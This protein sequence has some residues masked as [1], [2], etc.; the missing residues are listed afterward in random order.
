MEETTEELLDIQ[1]PPT[2][3]EDRGRVDPVYEVE[4]VPLPGGWDG[5]D[6]RDTQ[7]PSPS[8]S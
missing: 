7:T 6:P 3:T 4:E 2:L 8:S 5:V 1:P